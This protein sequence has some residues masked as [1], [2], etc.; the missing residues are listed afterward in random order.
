MWWK[1]VARFPPRF[2]TD[3]ISKRNTYAEK[4][5][6]KALIE[7]RRMEETRSIRG[8]RSTPAIV[9][10]PALERVEELEGQDITFPTESGLLIK[11]VHSRIL[12]KEIFP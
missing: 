10:A 4:S 9:G 8:T 11:L 12:G 6:P 5:G 2:D 3:G 7:A 1:T